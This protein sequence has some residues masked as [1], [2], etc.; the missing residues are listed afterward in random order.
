[1]K[2]KRDEPDTYNPGLYSGGEF[3]LSW[4][5]KEKAAGAGKKIEGKKRYPGILEEGLIYSCAG[6]RVD[7]EEA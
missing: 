1:M 2:L 5:S 3:P 7:P 6:P 4:D